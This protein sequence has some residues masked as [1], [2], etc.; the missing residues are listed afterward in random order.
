LSSTPTIPDPANVPRYPPLEYFFD[1]DRSRSTPHGRTRST[2]ARFAR[3]ARRDAQLRLA[4][5]LSIPVL[6]MEG[7]ADGGSHP[8]ATLLPVAFVAIQLGLTAL[9]AWPAWLAAARLVLSLAFVLI[10]D[11]ITGPGQTWPLNTLLIPIA[12]VAASMGGRA[13]LIVGASVVAALIPLVV[14]NVDG[15][16]RREAVAVAMVAVVIANGSRHVVRTLERSAE[17][18]RVAKSRDRRRARQFGALEA[19]GRL[20]AREG[21]T[22]DG[23]ERVMELLE[24]TFGYKYPSVYTWDG[25]LLQLGAQRNYQ[26]PIQT[27]PAD[28][29]VMGRVVRT[30]QAEFLPDARSDPDFQSGD[31]RVVSEIS[32]PLES[33]GEFLGILNVE[34]D[35]GHLLDQDD[36]A[37]M[38]IAGDRL[39]AAIALG[40]ERQKLTERTALLDR[41]TTF[42]GSLNA[43]LDPQTVHHFVVAGAARV[44]PA[45]MLVL[46]LRESDSDEFRTIA[47]EGGDERVVGA[48]I[49]PGEG[50]TGRAL[51]SGTLVVDDHLE[52]SSFPRSTANVRLADVLAAMSAP[53]VH[54]GTIVG[55]MTWLRE[56]T[57]RVFTTQEQ[58]VATLLANRVVLA[59]ANATLHQE[60]QEAAITDA[61]TGLHNRRHFD[62]AVAHADALRA[63]LAVGD[64]RERSAILFDLDHFGSIN[65]RHGHQVGDQILRAFADVLRSRVRASDLAARYGGEE[66]VVILDGASRDEA[67]RLADEIRI[68]F[69]QLSIDASDSGLP[70]TTVSAGCASLDRIETSGAVLVERADVGLA[71][72]K[73]AGRDQVVAA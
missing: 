10:A 14:P 67:V 7:M 15:E 38:L 62:A 69:R 35:G 33:N 31:P 25:T 52:R 43:S 49:V 65:K 57:A 71:M 18:I 60:V 50:I 4:V 36:F 12:A 55:A 16:V 54:D 45:D 21:P 1:P 64:R 3:R 48:R 63:R 42:E 20:L 19:V 61:L 32:V 27:L 13:L 51:A 9:R 37:T 6:I 40:R 72:A 56:D 53:L 73:A 30:R 23:L 47:V 26:F 11:V 58:E 46:V 39:A 44:V 68:A 5:A 66:F 28:Q 2:A 8:L 29:G 59:L 70:I 34:T 41:L 22:E 24:E 17:R